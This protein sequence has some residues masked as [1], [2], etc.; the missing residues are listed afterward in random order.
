MSV[1]DFIGYLTSWSFYRKYIEQNT[2]KADPILDIAQRSVSI[3]VCV[4]GCIVYILLLDTV[5]ESFWPWIL[6]FFQIQNN[7]EKNSKLPNN[8]VGMHKLI[9]PY[10]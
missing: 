2:D 5:L 3:H 4:V 7:L 9:T 8:V 6:F 1:S 10:V